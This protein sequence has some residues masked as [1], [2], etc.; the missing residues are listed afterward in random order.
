MSRFRRRWCA[1]SAASAREAGSI[2]ALFRGRCAFFRSIASSPSPARAMLLALG[3]ASPRIGREVAVFASIATHGP[4]K[5]S[6]GARLG[7]AARATAERHS[8]PA[9]GAEFDAL[10]ERVLA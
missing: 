9:S 5:A 8:E 3:R 1:F 10:R 4:I 2:G 7:K 6:F